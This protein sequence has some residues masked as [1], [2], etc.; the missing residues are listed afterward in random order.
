MSEFLL[1]RRT[2]ALL[3]IALAF[4][5]SARAEK[6]TPYTKSELEVAVPMGVPGVRAW[7]DAPLSALRQQVA[8]L[9]ALN[10]TRQ[11]S[12]KARG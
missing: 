5:T 10:A 12:A 8:H 1:H 6:R 7:A 11:F 3:V 4:G 2:F 9:P